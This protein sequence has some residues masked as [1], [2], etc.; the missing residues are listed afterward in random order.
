MVLDGT[1]RA[2]G[3][4]NPVALRD[5]DVGRLRAVL[6]EDAGDATFDRRFEL[7]REAGSGGMGR[8]LEAIDRESGA[9]VAVKLLARR[10]DRERFAAEAAVLERLTHPAIVRYVRHG[11][12]R[13][14]EPYLAM[15]WLVGESLAQ[16]LAR[17][18]LGV[19]DAC[20]VGERIA[21]ALEHA[22]AAGVV[23]RDVKPS[24]V[25]L[26]GGAVDE[27]RLID[28]GVAKTDRDLTSTGQLIGTPGYMAPEQVRG[29]RG[30]DG[31]V[32]L[33]A[34][35]CVLYEAVAGRA[36]F[37]GSEVMEVLA[38]LLLDRPR[39]LGELVPE[40]PPRL[41]RLVEALLAKDA[42]HR[43][44]DARVVREEL[45]AIRAALA[46]GDRAA[47]A[48]VSPAVPAL[49]AAAAAAAEAA[50]RGARPG[51]RGAR[52]SSR[53][54]RTRRARWP[55]LVAGVALA[56]AAA[57]AV[58][59]SAWR[60]RQ[61]ADP[62][63]SVAGGDRCTNYVRDGC[64]A[65]CGAGSADAC[66]RWGQGL[67]TGFGGVTVDRP[68]ALAAYAR[69]CELGA[70]QACI[71]G[72]TSLLRGD[73]GAPGADAVARAERMLASACDRGASQACR[74][75]GLGHAPGGAFA[76]DPA[77]A[78]RSLARACD[79]NDLPACRALRVQ[80]DA[81]LGDAA[82]RAAAEASHAGACRRKLRVDCR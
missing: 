41:D 80:L 9:R 38:R 24:N 54:G 14:G 60:A 74:H 15:A 30:V 44:G 21:A 70:L 26:V 32:D 75:L 10:A 33:F 31:R 48:A 51:G 63:V 46:A 12:T 66:L 4:D 56:A 53:T 59:V 5:E 47:L 42:A 68:A 18:P 79:G 81:G 1:R 28:F 55:W 52:R 71:K 64:E 57:L 6:G 35:G 7:V 8:V 16:R 25:I 17:G 3:Y 23:H 37:P 39:P 22:H 29:E 43:L 61:A 2:R 78:L 13:G 49:P 19:A 76:A 36:P 73:G 67:Y 27:A 20:M 77:L 82:S 65:A 40:I 34:L 11:V 62:P 50:T 58:S 69:G 72:A 45:A